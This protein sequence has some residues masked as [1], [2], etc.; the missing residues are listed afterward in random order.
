[1]AEDS[2]KV[3]DLA[4]WRQRRLR[5]QSQEDYIRKLCSRCEAPEACGEAQARRLAEIQRE[6][7][8]D[9]L[10]R[11]RGPQKRQGEEREPEG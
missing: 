1:M 8:L 3:I 4:G 6:V 11:G 7:I 5:L 10:C 2:S 9:L